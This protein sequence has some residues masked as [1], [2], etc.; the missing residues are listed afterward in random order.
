MISGSCI[1]A[2]ASCHS[3][4]ECRSQLMNLLTTCQAGDDVIGRPTLTAQDGVDD[5]S[6]SDEQW[7]GKCNRVDC[8]RAIRTFYS[9]AIYD[10][11]SSSVGRWRHLVERLHFCT[12]ADHRQQDIERCEDVRASLT[13]ACA[14]VELPPPTCTD[15]V[16]R[17]TDD[18]DCA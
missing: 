6:E 14:R 11:L 12:C 1:R 18:A 3:D 4:Y 8:L 7:R 16:R 9:G 5:V 17:C 2:L 13:P 15:L 10:S